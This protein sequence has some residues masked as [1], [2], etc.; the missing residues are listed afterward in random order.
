MGIHSQHTV[1]AGRKTDFEIIEMSPIDMPSW[2]E[3]NESLKYSEGYETRSKTV[4]LSQRK[5]QKIT[6]PIRKPRQNIARQPKTGAA[7]IGTKL[8]PLSPPKR[9]SALKKGGGRKLGKDIEGRGRGGREAGDRPDRSFRTIEE[10][11]EYDQSQQVNP[12]RAGPKP[13]KPKGKKKHQEIPNSHPITRYMVKEKN[14][15]GQ[16]DLPSILADLAAEAR[17]KIKLLDLSEINSNRTNIKSHKMRQ[18]R[19]PRYSKDKALYSDIISSTPEGGREIT[20]TVRG[21][22][23]LI[24]WDT[25]SEGNTHVMGTTD[26]IIHGNPTE[27]TG[28]EDTE[29]YYNFPYTPGNSSAWH[30]QKSRQ[31][32]ME[33]EYEQTGIE[34]TFPRLRLDTEESGNRVTRTRKDSSRYHLQGDTPEPLEVYEGTGTRG[35]PTSQS[36]DASITDNDVTAGEDEEHFLLH[37]DPHNDTAQYITVDEVS[38]TQHEPTLSSIQTAILDLKKELNRNQDDFKR[39]MVTS[40]DTRNEQLKDSVN[41]HLSNKLEAL[42]TEVSDRVKETYQPWIEETEDRLNKLEV[43]QQTKKGWEFQMTSRVNEMVRC[44]NFLTGSYDDLKEWEKKQEK[45]WVNLRESKQALDQELV[46]IKNSHEKLREELN[47]ME[48]HKRN[49]NVRICN[50]QQRDDREDSKQ[51]VADLIFT[52]RLLSGVRDHKSA[53]EVLEFCQRVGKGDGKQPRAIIATFYSRQTR[54]EFMINCKRSNLKPI[55]CTDDHTKTNQEKRQ[56]GQEFMQA[57]WNRGSRAHFRADGNVYIGNRLVHKQEYA[58]ARRQDELDRL[59]REGEDSRTGTR[60]GWEYGQSNG[61]GNDINQ[62]REPNRT[63]PYQE[64]RRYATQR[65]Y[66]PPNRRPNFQQWGGNYASTMGNN[67]WG[68][69]QYNSPHY[70]AS[71]V[72]YEV[73][74]PRVSPMRGPQP[75]PILHTPYSMHRPANQNLNPNSTWYNRLEYNML[76]PTPPR[77]SYNRRAL[78]HSQ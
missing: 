32:D 23:P 41:T 65:R 68:E 36:S 53:T 8:T 50:L 4:N 33:G 39:A 78:D 57:V 77:R 28:I 34:D 20:S 22:I 17:D 9:R 37:E 38:K 58:L 43:K 1:M 25:T 76:A 14:K 55:F 11:I 35:R 70:H 10:W 74:Y 18:R 7:I 2:I 64:N 60:T 51:T 15:N 69:T 30:P 75:I 44:T 40:W 3:P 19:V 71:P 16:E 26:A 21:N 6:A 24:Q 12:M 5:V 62:R 72:N 67:R 59:I 27:A 48:Q 42:S 46:N 73:D 29:M 31:E 13:L 54:N 63:G 52:R 47:N 45:Q 49:Y 66:S 56:E 61:A